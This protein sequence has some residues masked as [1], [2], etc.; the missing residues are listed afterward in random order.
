MD[1]STSL[2]SLNSADFI[3]IGKEQPR[4]KVA[5]GGG[6]T[7][8]ENNMAE[9]L[10]ESSEQT[11]PND[12]TIIPESNP[13]P[14][15][16]ENLLQTSIKDDISI[17]K[18][19]Q[20]PDLTNNVLFHGVTYLGSASINAPRSEEELNRNMAILNEQSKLPIEVT[21]CVPD[22]ANGVVRLLD[23]QTELEII[24]YRISQILFCARGPSNTPLAC[25]WAFTTSRMSTT[26]NSSIQQNEN[27]KV[28]QELLYQCQVFRCDI[29]DAIYKIL[30][31]FA[32]AF[33][34]SSSS[35]N[36]STSSSGTQSSV[37]ISRRTTSLIG[38]AI[39]ATVAQ[40]QQPS[41]NS[42]QSS[43]NQQQL[44]QRPSDGT[45]KFRCYSDIKEEAIDNKGNINFTSVPRVEKNVFRL[46]TDV[47]KNVTVA[48]QQIR[49][50]PLNIERCFGMLLAQ[51]R[52]VRASDMQ[53]LDLDSMGKSEDNRYYMVRANWDPLARGFKELTHLNEETPK[54]ARVFLTIALDLVISGIQEPVRFLIEAKAR[55]CVSNSKGDILSQDI[56]D[57][58]W[59]SFK[60]L[61][62]FTEEF[63]MILK[64]VTPKSPSSSHQDDT[65][66]VTLLES[67]SES[68]RRAKL[69]Q[70]AAAAEEDDDEPMVSGFGH[71]SKECDEEVLGNWSDILTKWRKN[72]SERPRGLQ[73]LVRKGIPEALRGEVWQLLAG[74][75]GDE[76]EM[77]NTYRLLLTK[78][79]SSERV[80]LNDLNRT[81]PAHEYFKDAGGIGQEALYKLS[82]AYSV[83]DEEVGYCQGLSFVI[84]TLLIHMPEEQA[85]M[86]L[87]KLMEDPRYI[88]R[89]MYKANFENL[90]VRFHQ[91]TCLI[92]DN[93]PDLYAHFDDLK[94]ECHMYA[95]QWFL[96]LFTAKFP[97]YLVF[98][99]M[100]IFLYE[101]FNALFGVGLALLK[102]C[103][104]DL[105]SLD[106]EGIMR[107]FR[108]NLPKKYRSEDH[109]DEL[110][111]TAC[112]MK[113]NVKKLKRYE[114]D[115]FT[116]RAEEEQGELPLQRLELDNKRLT[117]TC[118]RSELE[119][120]MLALELVNDRV[121]L[122]SSLDEAED[123]IETLTRELQATR[124]IVR[125]SEQHTIRLD[126]E[127]ENIRE[128]FRRTCDEL[129]QTQKIVT[130][131]KNICSQ[132]NN[133][134]DKQKEKYQNKIQSIQN[135][136][137]DSC[138]TSINGTISPASSTASTPERESINDDD[139]NDLPP[140]SS[141]PS[142]VADRLRQVEIEL[143]EKKLALT[144]AL[145]ENQELAHQLRHSTSV[146]SDSD[147][148]SVN[149]MRSINNNN[150]NN[151]T[152]SWLSKT[153]NTIKEAASSTNRTKVN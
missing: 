61:S 101:G 129:Q 71:V 95:S 139:D 128:A 20:R 88:L 141:I 9:I 80:I 109:A 16:D 78:E 81:F 63:D 38:Q 45:I 76:N 149:S 40:L 31:S 19:Q 6:S 4:L 114:K 115:F 74:S 51:G 72:Y 32:N 57:T 98:R 127:L 117:E 68:E 84:A 41:S 34:R 137:C 111:Q 15:S 62:P 37:S 39:Q 58:I 75:V 108:V 66:E 8:L 29:Q 3:F 23:P 103:Q 93:L 24:S 55:V 17:T 2:S 132:L 10:N 90:Q 25:C 56:S 54:G 52:N 96:T 30:L 144:Q 112:S 105:L 69:R 50:F 130:D 143:A 64:E 133:Q 70:T 44:P 152:V 73:S 1:D 91:L 85:F 123:R 5:A 148:Q 113:I 77:I 18:Q 145:C 104:K 12:S 150:N 125:E 102:S 119:N 126:E 53:L 60:K 147:T 124:S 138:K 13:I 120:E 121:K 106:F 42:N 49:G 59:S 110:I 48:L 83:R 151:S 67:K 86:L 26:T 118:M 43:N 11:T 35:S 22:N 87:C 28:Q 153:V 135:R 47:R 146:T 122:K 21:L 7:D 33:R 14:Q 94:V 100:D 65:Y 107:F 116:R 142:S 92:Q 89:E 36:N 134:L 27:G 136:C 46:R 82:R 140:I 131:Y 99:I 79:S 97:L